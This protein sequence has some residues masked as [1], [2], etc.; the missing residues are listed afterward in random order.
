ETV[1]RIAA[2]AFSVEATTL[3]AAATL[4]RSLDAA[5]AAGAERPEY[6][7]ELPSAMFE[8]EIADEQAQVTVPEETTRVPSELF[9]TGGASNTAAKKSIDL[10]WRI[11][12]T[13]PT[14]HPT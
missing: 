6:D 7:G 2:T 8:A 11:A 5:V 10:H 4:D 3:H 1:G 13:V 14:Q 12:T 9:L